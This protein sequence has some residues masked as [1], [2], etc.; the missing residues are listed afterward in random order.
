MPS[1]EYYNDNAEAFVERT[2]DV[3]VSH[4][5]D[6]FLQ[7]LPEKAH[8]LDAGFGSGRDAKFFQ[9]N[10]FEVTAFDASV[11]MVK[12]SSNLLGK[13]T[14]HMTFLDIDDESRFDAMWAS[15][16]LI[17]VPY[18]EQ[19][20]V[21]KLLHRSLKCSGIFFASYKY[22]QTQRD[23]AGRSFFDM[24][25]NTIQR[26]LKGLFEV[27]EI[28]STPDRISNFSASPAKKWLNILCKKVDN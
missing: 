4:I 26:Y 24:D 10:G 18:D 7:Y 2:I 17:H 20:S 16:S 19:A 13:P 14:L 12:I 11:E 15:A 27:I 9:D 22:G 8:I 6:P 5:H 3:D 25:E 28:W 1:V 23:V 21:M